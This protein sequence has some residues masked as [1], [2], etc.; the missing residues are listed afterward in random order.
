MGEAGKAWRREPR[1]GGKFV[2]AEMLFNIS[3]GRKKQQTNVEICKSTGGR[4]RRVWIQP[5]RAVRIRT[6]EDPGSRISREPPPSGGNSPLQKM[7][8]SL[9]RTPNFPDSHF[10]D[11]AYAVYIQSASQ[12]FCLSGRSF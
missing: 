12:D 3:P 1:A 4:N 2:A 8:A 11:W 6:T 10:A 7:R 5:I 9:G